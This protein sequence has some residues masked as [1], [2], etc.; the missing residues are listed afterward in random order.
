[1]LL[2]VNPVSRGPRICLDVFRNTSLVSM[3][4]IDFM[5]HCQILDA[6]ISA[7][8]QL[9]VQPA[10]ISFSLVQLQYGSKFV[11]RSYTTNRSVVGLVLG[12][13]LHQREVSAIH[14]LQKLRSV[15]SPFKELIP[16]SSSSSSVLA[17]SEDG[18]PLLH[19]DKM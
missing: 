3:P 15:S 6:S 19:P 2:P 17:V 13:Y 11:L 14:I 8:E 18:S 5:L 7:H 9:R 10:P 12:T 4:K 16:P 1:M